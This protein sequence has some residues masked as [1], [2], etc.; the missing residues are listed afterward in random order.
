M[1]GTENY[2]SSVLLIK[3]NK[4]SP[5]QK[6]K[7]I[8]IWIKGTIQFTQGNDIWIGN[9]YFHISKLTDS[10][11]PFIT[12]RGHRDELFDRNGFHIK[13]QFLCRLYQN[14]IQL[15]RRNIVA[16]KIDIDLK[17]RTS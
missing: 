17:T 15:S 6:Y 13:L 4:V 1:R 9:E 16:D 7:I 2:V 14:L 10:D 12:S 5:Y 11:C 8:E 3:L